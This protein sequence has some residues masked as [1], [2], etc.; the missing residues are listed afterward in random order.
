MDSCSSTGTQETSEKKRQ[1]NVLAVVPYNP[2]NISTLVEDQSS[3]T[4]KRM[5]VD[6]SSDLGKGV[7]HCESSFM[8]YRIFMP[9]LLKVFHYYY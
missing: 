8:Q 2:K 5:L 7:L 1:E 3:N 4:L 9:I 6:T